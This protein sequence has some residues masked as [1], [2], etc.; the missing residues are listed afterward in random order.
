MSRS[1]AVFGIAL[2]VLVIGGHAAFAGGPSTGG[3]LCELLHIGCG[4]NGN[5]NPAPAPLLAAGIPAFTALGGGMLVSR[6]FRK[7]KRQS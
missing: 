5:G 4:G 7:F 6:L 3:I 1:I 2:A